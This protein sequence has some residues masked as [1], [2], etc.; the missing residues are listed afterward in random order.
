METGN[1]GLEEHGSGETN[2]K[3]PIALLIGIRG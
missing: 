1:G 2:F 3:S